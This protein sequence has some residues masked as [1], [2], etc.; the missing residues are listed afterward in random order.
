MSV[1]PRLSVM[2]VAHGYPP[3]RIGGVELY[4]RTLHESLRAAGVDSTVFAAGSEDRRLDG[5]REVLGPHPRPRSFRGTLIRPR[6]EARFRAWLAERRPHIVHIHH[7]AH[8]SLGLPRVAAELG[9]ATV[10]TLH[11]YQL[12]CVRGQLVDRSLS[13]CPGP[14][15]ARCADCVAGQLALSPSTAW[16]AGAASPL[17][18]GLRSQAREGLGRARRGMPEIIAERQRLVA[19]AIARVRRFAAPS[20]DLARRVAALGVPAD[21]IDHVELPLVH[22]VSAAPPPGQG[23]LRFLFLGSM[24][25]TK[26]PHLLLEAFSRL[27]RG[28]A[29]LLL[30][31]PRPELDLDPTY[32]ERLAARAADTPDARLQGPFAPG[33]VQPLLDDADVLVVPSLWEEN[34]PLVVREATAAG[35]R[36]VASRRGGIREL[37]PDARLFEPTDPHALERAL[38]AEL[39]RGRGRAEPRRWDDP[40]RHAGRV[41][42]WYHD[43]LT[44]G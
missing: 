16:L 38:R 44:A 26:A 10:M 19:A 41:I 2:Q 43:R 1:E 9:I 8:L 35:L 42:A 37:A 17:P 13:R 32:A 5:R 4:V 20:R 36:V 6:V 27:P 3:A 39:A 33:G 30:V 34:S 14:A 25:P 40:R 24:I 18:P 11:D 28:A 12:F 23:P 15:P 21:R 7:L 29:S 31:G 22:P